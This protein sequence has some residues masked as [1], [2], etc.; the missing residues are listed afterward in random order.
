MKYFTGSRPTRPQEQFISPAE[1]T[2][3]H[4]I[5]GPNQLMSFFFFF[6]LISKHADTSP[7]SNFCLFVFQLAVFSV[8]LP[9]CKLQTGSSARLSGALM[10]LGFF[11]YHVNIM[12][13]QNSRKG[14]CIC[15]CVMDF[16]D[17]CH[18]SRPRGGDLHLPPPNGVAASAVNTFLAC[19]DAET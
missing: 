9:R 8:T 18:L 11:F 10:G 7:A 13:P 1:E 6:F 14:G 17:R 16:P 12:C 4:K 2:H 5:S 19:G 3:T 15:D